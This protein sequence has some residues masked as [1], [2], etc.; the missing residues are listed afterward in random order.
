M[1]LSRILKMLLLSMALILSFLAVPPISTQASTDGS[2]IVEF[3]GPN[4][5]IVDGKNYTQAI[6]FLPNIT[7]QSSVSDLTD[8]QQVPDSIVAMLPIMNQLANNYLT[9]A[10]F[11]S[12]VKNQLG[13]TYAESD[14]TESTEV[15]QGYSVNDGEI[16]KLPTEKLTLL[17]EP[18]IYYV[19]IPAHK[20]NSAA[21][22]TVTIKDVA[23]NVLESRNVTGNINDSGQFILNDSYFTDSNDALVTSNHQLVT[24]TPNDYLK[25]KINLSLYG[26]DLTLDGQTNTTYTLVPKT[27]VAVTIHYRSTTGKTLAADKTVSG[28]TLTQQT[29]A[30]PAIKGYTAKAPTTTITF[31]TDSDATFTYTQDAATSSSSS[32]A[33]VDSSSFNSSSSVT[34]SSST[35]STSSTT[36]AP[37]KVFQP[38]QVYVKKGLYTYQHPTFKRSERVHHFAELPQKG[39]IFTVVGTAKSKSGILRYQLNNGAYITAD[40]DYVANLYWQGSRYTK[41]KVTS[42]KGAY[43][44]RSATLAKKNRGRFLKKGTT[45]KVTKLV[46][47][48]TMTRYQLANGQYLTGNK[49]FVSLK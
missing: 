22:K 13:V 49:Q 42:A 16:A 47:R 48:G 32:S 36:T 20:N 18:N 6:T 41:L 11:I 27:P 44:Y 19:V 26:F 23:G 14:I 2:T 25:K 12:A 38:I 9:P 15:F 34:S 7:E 39:R 24:I 3:Y 31:G 43:Q 35:A 45:V 4:Q 29:L 33:V 5:P 37:T 1:K 10:Q 30:A 17:K 40:P 8:D 28:V 21:T 46:R